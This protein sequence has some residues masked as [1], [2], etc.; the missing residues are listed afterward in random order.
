MAATRR[1][2]PDPRHGKWAPGPKAASTLPA[3]VHF[4]CV[5]LA[6]DA[7]T[8]PNRV[9]EIDAET[10]PV[11]RVKE[12]DIDDGVIAKEMTPETEKTK[13]T[14]RLATRRKTR[15]RSKE[16]TN[17]KI[18]TKEEIPTSK[19]RNHP[20]AE[21]GEDGPEIANN[22]A[23]TPL[24][25]AIASRNLPDAVTGRIEGAK[26]G[27]REALQRC[28]IR[29]QIGGR[30][31]KAVKGDRK[32]RTDLDERKSTILRKKYDNIFNTGSWNQRTTST[33]I[34]PIKKSDLEKTKMIDIPFHRIARNINKGRHQL[35][36]LPL[37]L[38]PVTPMEIRIHQ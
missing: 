7:D 13:K 8:A 23:T 1:A 3:K 9:T 25:T 6:A 32:D 12:E 36:R 27:K 10:R 15:I 31:K 22:A 29:I 34:F 21:D 17:R 5:V 2:V 37:V 11:P 33:A 28:S 24:T 16:A 20:A 26:I 18:E 14:N 35:G 30:E 38:I 19:A 4:P